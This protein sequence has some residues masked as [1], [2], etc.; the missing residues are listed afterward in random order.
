VKA[1]DHAKA[2]KLGNEVERYLHR[3]E[4]RVLRHIK[5]GD[6]SPWVANLIEEHTSATYTIAA[7]E[8]CRGGSLQRHLE[9]LS[10]GGRDKSGHLAA[11][12][13]SDVARFGGQVSAAL[14]HLHRLC[15]VHRDLKPANILFYGECHLKLCDFG[16]ALA[17]RDGERLHTICGTPVYMAP[18]LTKSTRGMHKRGYQG[19]PVDVWAFG[20]LVYEMLHSRLA[21]SG[22][23]AEELFR[24]IRAGTHA[25]LREHVSKELRALIKGCLALAPSRRPTSFELVGCPA[26]LTA[27]QE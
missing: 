16:F 26:L 11:M 19:P 27:S 18:E 6:S 8:L 23:S 7:L 4:L 14:H 12:A 13:A 21:F 5:S 22:S 2:S 15:V 10:K 3:R 17:C 1:F 20:C 25:P 9:K 24:R